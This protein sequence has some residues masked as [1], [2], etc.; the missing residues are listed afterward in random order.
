MDRAYPGMST[1][2]QTVLLRWNFTLEEKNSLGIIF[3]SYLLMLLLCYHVTNTPGR[4][5]LTISRSRVTVENDCAL[6]YISPGRMTRIP[7]QYKR[8]HMDGT[9]KVVPNMFTQLIS[10]HCEHLQ[11]VFLVMYTNLQITVE[12]CRS[13]YY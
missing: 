10:I 11:E 12:W 8:I 9:F 7:E 1:K 5:K 6:I 2:L 3:V 4:N 13:V